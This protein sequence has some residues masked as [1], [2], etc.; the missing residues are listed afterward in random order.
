[1]IFC[2]RNVKIEIEEIMSENIASVVVPIQ[3]LKMLLKEDSEERIDLE[4][5]GSL[6]GPAEAGIGLIVIFF[7]Q[8]V[9]N[10]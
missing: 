8:R 10:Y 9:Q 7:V 1:M 2:N 3:L 6:V 5:L 4:Q